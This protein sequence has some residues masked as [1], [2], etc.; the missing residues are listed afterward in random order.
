MWSDALNWFQAPQMLI[1]HDSNF[2]MR[3]SQVSPC[4]LS[5]SSKLI[6]PILLLRLNLSWHPLYLQSLEP[7]GVEWA[8]RCWGDKSPALT[9]LEKKKKNLPKYFIS[10]L[11]FNPEQKELFLYLHLYIS[12]NL[13]ELFNY[14][15]LLYEYYGMTDIKYHQSRQ[16]GGAEILQTPIEIL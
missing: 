15:S 12:Y 9:K 11:R 14:T 16:A 2:S 10:R 1:S 7:A 13:R 3:G 4:L 8:S 5:W 6:P